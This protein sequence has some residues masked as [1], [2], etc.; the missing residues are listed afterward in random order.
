MPLLRFLRAY[1]LVADVYVQSRRMT[2]GGQALTDGDV[3]IA[4]AGAQKPA[5][6]VNGDLSMAIR[7][8]FHGAG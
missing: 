2:R 8:L 3:T 4:V 7:V 5:L 6:L 1:A